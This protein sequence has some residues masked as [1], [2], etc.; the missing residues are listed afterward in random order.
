[1]DSQRRQAD[2]TENEVK[3][4]VQTALKCFLIRGS[5]EIRKSLALLEKQKGSGTLKVLTGT[6]DHNLKIILMIT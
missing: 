1:M 6:N 3:G 4:I 2:S 5:R